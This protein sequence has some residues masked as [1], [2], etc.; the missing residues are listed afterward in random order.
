MEI[1]DIDLKQLIENETGDRFNK[2]NKI[3]CPLPGHNEKTPSFSIYFNPD[4]NKFM[5]KCFG[6]CKTSGDAIDFIRAYKNIGYKEAR[7]YLGLE[8]E[9]DENE[10]KENQIKSYINW[11]INNQDH[12]KG[13]QLLGI[14]PFTNDKN[15]IVYYKA[16]F[17]NGK[18]KSLQY[19]HFEN[20]KVVNNRG[21]NEL[22]YNFYN[23]AQGIKDRKVIVI[24]EGEKDANTINYTLRNTRYVA[25]SLKGVKDF[26]I[27]NSLDIRIYVIGDTGEAGEQY[28]WHIYHALHEKCEEFKFINLPG[29]KSLGDN[30][31]VTDW[32]NSGHS[33]NDLLN[34]F[35]RS[36]NMKSRYDLQQDSRGI[37]KFNYDK[38][39]ETWYKFYLTDFKVIEAT[40]MIF[41]DRDTEGVRLVL[42]SYTGTT[43]EKIGEAKVFD[44]LKSFRNFLG[45]M[46]LTFKGKIDDLMTFKQWINKYFAIENEEMYTGISFIN[47]NN[48]YLLVTNEGA[49]TTSGNNL[50]LRADKSN[51]AEVIDKE[52]I[53]TNELKELKKHLFKF[54]GPEK[55]ICIIGTTINS[56]AS[57]L[58][59]EANS[60]MHHLLIVGESESGK[61]TILE[62]IIAPILN[63]PVEDIKS[64]GGTSPFALI[65]S[66]SEGN[67]PILFDEFKPSRMDRYK[68]DKISDTLRNLYDRAVISRG[69]KTFKNRDFRL[70]RP[71]MMCGEES[72]PRQEK[73]LMTRSCICY[74]SKRE[75]TEEN[76]D[77]MKWLID[78]KEILN[79]LGRSLIDVVLNMTA[80]QYKNLKNEAV[81]KFKLKD[82]P[83]NTAA[84]IAVGIDILNILLEK[85]KLKI[86]SN[87]EQYIE[88]NIKNEILNGGDD[89]YSVVEQ[90][91]ILYNSM[92]E[93]GRAFNS[94]NTV[95]VKKEGVFIKTS[96]LVYQV[97]D[98]INRVDSVDVLPLKLKD[99]TDQAM[100][101]GYLVKRSGKVV[102]INQKPIKF[103][104]YNRDLLRNLGVNTI[105]DEEW[106]ETDGI[107]GSFNEIV[108]GK[109][110]D[111]KK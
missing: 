103:D 66:L 13:K 84:N 79:K 46:D 108:N 59:E 42:K 10:K 3:C 5:W 18:T 76:S 110:V 111:F 85:H 105:L 54:L 31:D 57:L 9:E 36:L 23:L 38:K 40:R 91:L 51:N 92:M 35:D 100:K 20:D 77:A 4:K 82:R 96:E 24:V 64:I 87:H 93:D 52:L 101:S 29:I 32:L 104:V 102:K 48:E 33:K 6:K 8:S 72:Y 30:K 83:L 12:M 94:E 89:A 73:A 17:T 61:S 14:Y 109:V 53:T 60:K 22:P 41:K 49:I 47:R 88:K 56:L 28:K 21:T 7:K 68:I 58:N 62:N 43:I 71:L 11:Q 55:S 74:I 95:V 86:I 107:Q 98:Y 99:F 15:E 67:Y 80:N 1:N 25:T 2:E 45:S 70:K 34:A 63:Y 27:F 75:R 78:N 44:D 16:K 106:D 26:S 65:K 90:M 69:D 50:N 37:Y 81:K 39:D 19:Y 97:H